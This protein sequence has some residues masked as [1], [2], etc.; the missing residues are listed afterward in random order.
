MPRAKYTITPDDV[1]HATFYIRGRLQASGFE[2]VDSIS[3]ENVERGFTAAADVKSRVDRAAA[4]NAWCETYLGSE[5]WKRLK[6]AIRKRR[7]RT[8]HYDEQH[9]IT[10]SKKAHHLLSKVAERDDVTFSEVLEHYLFK[11]FNTSRGRA[12]KGRTTRR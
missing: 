8:E 12:S 4:V 10:I 1:V 11:A 6:T 5:E 3:L 7:Y 2:F 9:T